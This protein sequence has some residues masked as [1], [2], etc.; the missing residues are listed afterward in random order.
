MEQLEELMDL[1]P[2]PTC[3]R[4]YRVGL[5]EADGDS[6]LVKNTAEGGNRGEAGDIFTGTRI[7]NDGTTPS[8]RLNSGAPSAVAL[9]ITVE[10]GQARIGVFRRPQVP[11]NVLLGPYLGTAAPSA[12]EQAAVDALGNGNGR[13]DLGDVRAYLRSAGV[14]GQ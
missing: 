7:L 4:L 5:V 9:S 11:G 13:Y 2:C 1:R 8:I 12:E 6:S 10:G 3:A 14:S